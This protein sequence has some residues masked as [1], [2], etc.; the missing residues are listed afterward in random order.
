MRREKDTINGKVE[1]EISESE[2]WAACI[3]A[4]IAAIVIA[5]AAYNVAYIVYTPPEAR[6]KFDWQARQRI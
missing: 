4:C 2:V 1:W 6:L 5:V 3:C